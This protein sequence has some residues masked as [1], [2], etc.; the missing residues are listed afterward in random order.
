MGGTAPFCGASCSSDCATG[1]FCQEPWSEGAWCVTGHKIC[2]CSLSN[3]SKETNQLTVDDHLP[4]AVTVAHDEYCKNHDECFSLCQKH[5]N[6]PGYVHSGCCQWDVMSHSITWFENSHVNGNSYDP[7]VNSLNCFQ[8][9]GRCD[10]F[11]VNKQCSWGIKDLAKLEKPKPNSSADNLRGTKD[12]AKL[13]K[14][15]PN[16][17]ADNLP[18]AVTVAQ[19]EYCADHDECFSLCQKHYNPPGYVH[20]GCCQWDVMSH[21][22]TWFENGHVNG[23]SYDPY[24]NSLNC[25]QSRGRC[26]DFTVNKQCSW[27][28]KDH[29]PAPTLRIEATLLI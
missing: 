2:C 11:T 15:K 27:G 9:R 16:S 7:Y 22:I 29:A 4:A 5:Y 12:L 28:T 17:S 21:S 25:F 18:A 26:D 20:S 10:D 19:P 6:P 3:Q 1:Q 23:N 24:V 8:S 14:P 13:E